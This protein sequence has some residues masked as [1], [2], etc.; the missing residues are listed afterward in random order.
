MLQQILEITFP[1]RLVF[2]AGIPFLPGPN[3]PSVSGSVHSP[4]EY[5]GTGTWNPFRLDCLD[6]SR[7]V[8]GSRCDQISAAVNYICTVWA[9]SEQALQPKTEK[10]TEKEC[11]EYAQYLF[12]AFLEGYGS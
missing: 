1:Y 10:I 8:S 7:K 9:H 3:V 6:C 2:H 11:I 4:C 5:R 12:G